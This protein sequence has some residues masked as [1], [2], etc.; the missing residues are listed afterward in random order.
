MKDKS[1]QKR[2]FENGDRSDSAPPTNSQQEVMTEKPSSEELARREEKSKHASKEAA[3]VPEN[4][5]D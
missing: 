3:P 1:V 5:I 2:K 4:Q